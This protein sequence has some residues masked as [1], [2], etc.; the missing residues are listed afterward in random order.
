MLTRCASSVRVVAIIII[1]HHYCVHHFCSLIL[2]YFGILCV[3]IHPVDDLCDF[4]NLI[5]LMLSFFMQQSG[6]INFKEFICALSITS[7]GN[8][9]EKLTCLCVKAFLLTIPAYLRMEFFASSTITPLDNS[10]ILSLRLHTF[11]ISCNWIWT[12]Q[13]ISIGG[14]K[15]F[16]LMLSWTMMSL[17]LLLNTMMTTVFHDCHKFMPSTILIFQVLSCLCLLSFCFLV[18]LFDVREG[19][20]EPNR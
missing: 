7:R 19:S 5:F 3:D 9:D 17:L 4:L 6:T 18:A 16:L 11:L 1:K 2:F 10:Q 12:C 14:T 13:D 15:F 8:M 20:W